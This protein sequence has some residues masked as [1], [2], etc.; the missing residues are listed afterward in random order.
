MSDLHVVEDFRQA[1][2]P[3]GERPNRRDETEVEERTSGDFGT[4]QADNLACGGQPMGA[5]CTDPDTMMP[6]CVRAC[7]SAV[8]QPCCQLRQVTGSR[9]CGFCFVGQPVLR[10][11]SNLHIPVVGWP[12]TPVRVSGPLKGGGTWLQGD[13]DIADGNGNAEPDQFVVT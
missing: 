10:S 2:Q 5:K 8:D 6:S 13:I 9:H 7:R 12:W 1:Q 11:Y 4:P 3:G